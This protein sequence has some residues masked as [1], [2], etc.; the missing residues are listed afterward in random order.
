[1]RLYSRAEQIRAEQLREERRKKGAYCAP[2]HTATAWK[3]QIRTRT[4]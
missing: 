4:P 1:M 3:N 2:S